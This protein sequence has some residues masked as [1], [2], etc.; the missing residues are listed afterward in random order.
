MVLGHQPK[1]W[2]LSQRVGKSVSER[3]SLLEAR[4]TIFWQTAKEGVGLTGIERQRDG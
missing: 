2:T 1:D 3:E 4:G